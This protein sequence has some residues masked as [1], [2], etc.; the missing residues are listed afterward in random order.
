MGTDSVEDFSRKLPPNLRPSPETTQTDEFTSRK[1]LERVDARAR[2]Y[3]KLLTPLEISALEWRDPQLQS[4][5]KLRSFMKEEGESRYRCMMLDP[6]GKECGKL[7]KAPEF[8][9]K[10]LQ[11]KHPETTSI[12]EEARRDAEYT[13]A[14]VRDPGRLSV[15]KEVETG[16]YGERERERRSTGSGFG[17]TPRGR[18]GINSRLGPR[19][20]EYVSPVSVPVAMMGRW[21]L[22]ERSESIWMAC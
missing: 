6:T 17:G 14:Y 18:G 4:E 15:M 1:A 7:F 10:H 8:V 13:N 21:V 9:E 3:G 19:E 11:L 20:E 5:S 22:S 2:Y 12:A 16:R